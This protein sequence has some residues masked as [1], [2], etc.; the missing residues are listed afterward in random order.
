MKSRRSSGE[1]FGLAFLDVI[2]CAFGAIVLLLLISKPALIEV[3]D[4]AQPSVDATVLEEAADLVGRLRV[5][6]EALQAMLASE[7][8]RPRRAARP[9]SGAR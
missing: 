2:S 3:G 4:E 7:P 6:W 1:V 5:R 9:G 8:K